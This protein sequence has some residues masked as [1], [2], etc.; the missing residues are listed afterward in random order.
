[1]IFAIH[2]PIIAGSQNHDQLENH[3]RNKINNCE[4]AVIKISVDNNEHQRSKGSWCDSSVL[5]KLKVL[6]SSRVE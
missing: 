5:Q 3:K 2:R 6:Y 4:S 1:M